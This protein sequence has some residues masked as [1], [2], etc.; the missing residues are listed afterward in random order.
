MNALCLFPRLK[1]LKKPKSLP[2]PVFSKQGQVLATGLGK[3]RLLASARL[4]AHVCAHTSIHTHKHCDNFQKTTNTA[5]RQSELISPS[6][7]STVIPLCAFLR[8]LEIE[9]YHSTQRG[10]ALQRE[11]TDSWRCGLYPTPSTEE[12]STE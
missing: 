6:K 12:A 1:F 5:L 10:C 2:H 8:P 9:L 11:I 4:K 7:C 3:Q